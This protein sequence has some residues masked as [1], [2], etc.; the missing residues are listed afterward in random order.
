MQLWK[1]RPVNK[2]NLCECVRYLDVFQRAWDWTNAQVA[3]FPHTTELVESWKR[4]LVSAAGRD[5]L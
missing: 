5:T 1:R 2:P 3:S 4:V